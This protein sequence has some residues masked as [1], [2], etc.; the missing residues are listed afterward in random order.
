MMKIYIQLPTT[1]EMSI[2]TLHFVTYAIYSY[3]FC[4]QD[5]AKS[6]RILVKCFC[7]M[8]IFFFLLQINKIRVRGNILYLTVLLKISF[9]K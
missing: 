4:F 8:R 3:D 6:Y 5:R 7:L 9:N 1:K 2:D